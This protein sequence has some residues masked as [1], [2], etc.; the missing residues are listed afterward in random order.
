VTDELSGAND[1]GAAVLAWS[2]GGSIPFKGVAVDDARSQHVGHISIP[3]M[4]K[5]CAT[6]NRPLHR[7]GTH[8]LKDAGGGESISF[9]SL[10]SVFS[11]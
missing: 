9:C 6:I 11:F 2:C 1:D 10:F 8:I 4:V 3:W 7:Y 5:S